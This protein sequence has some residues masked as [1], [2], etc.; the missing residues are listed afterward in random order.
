MT[1]AILFDTRSIQ[2]YIFSG[3]KLRTNIGASYIV[4]HVFESQLIKILK[5]KFDGQ[6]DLESW[7]DTEE[8][9]FSNFTEKC[10][11]AYIGGGNALVLFQE[12][13]DD[14]VLKNIVTEFTKELLVTYPG[15]KTGAAIG[16][17]DLSS[18][19]AYQKSDDDL[20]K[21]LK[22]NQN[23]VFPQ[24]NVPYT[25]LTQACSINGEVADYW[26]THHKIV[27]GQEGKARFFSQEVAAKAMIAKK[28]N[29]KLHEK[30]VH[31]IGNFLFPMELDHLG[32]QET[33]NYIAIVHVD[34]NNMGKKFMDCKSLA[35]RVKLSK[36]VKKKTETAFARLLESIVTE[37]DTYDR[38]LKLEANYLPIRPLILGGDDATFICAG[39]MALTYAKR[40]IE[41]M[42]ENNS[43]L[44]I[45]C[46][47]GVAILPTSY[48]FFRGYELAEQLCD[49]AKKKS[50]KKG[51]SWLDFARLHGEQAPTLDQ[52]RQQE[53]RGAQGDLHFGPY[54][55]G[56]PEYYYS[57]DKL[58]DCI[59]QLNQGII[60]KDNGQTGMAKNKIKEM[61][62]VLQHGEHACHQF[63]EQLHHIE[64]TLPNVLG[65]EMYK[66]NLW[67]KKQTPYVDAIEMMDFMP[68]EGE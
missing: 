16:E 19:E 23:T 12:D 8:A 48:P 44:G 61:R 3:N 20:H 45:E 17:L 29:E 21:K 22:H 55:V 26:D 18:T 10:R 52:I 13:T 59:H 56:E 35:K 24:V 66:D 15:L 34:G 30:F 36:D 68:K 67:D 4:E 41:Y 50:R 62:D 39:K 25:G 42:R 14:S 58:F 49:E 33:K 6:A 63:V 64:Q 9:D 57:I 11:I 31:S 37:Y 60:K 40:F 38:E 43:L 7:Q 5:N 54:K 53:Y 46:C 28:A 27:P 65:W 51:D 2:Q 32:Q 47:G 1:K